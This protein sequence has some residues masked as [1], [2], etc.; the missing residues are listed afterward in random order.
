MIVTLAEC[1][2]FWQSLRERKNFAGRGCAAPRGAQAPRTPDFFDDQSLRSRTEN[3]GGRQAWRSA[4]AARLGG[5][6]A[7]QTPRGVFLAR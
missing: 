2:P 5:L 4:Y 6:R 7:P 1:A 3:S